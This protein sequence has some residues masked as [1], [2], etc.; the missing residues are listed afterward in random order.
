MPVQFQS[1]HEK[2][3]AQ[4]VAGSDDRAV[5]AFNPGVQILRGVGCPG[6]PS[7]A[8]KD[9]QLLGGAS[10]WSLLRKRG[11]GHKGTWPLFIWKGQRQQGWPQR[12]GEKT[13][14][15]SPGPLLCQCL[16][17]TTHSEAPESCVSAV[18]PITRNTGQ[19]K[20]CLPKWH[21]SRNTHSPWN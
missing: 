15:S 4:P 19:A 3:T 17:H 14:H 11:W 16:G 12:G 10:H 6:G 8:G 20:H 1:W 13:A 5:A 21:T 9:P 2:S 18:V 7:Q